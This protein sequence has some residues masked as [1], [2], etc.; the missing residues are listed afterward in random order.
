MRHI[1]S[2]LKQLIRKQEELDENIKRL[3]KEREEVTREIIDAALKELEDDKRNDSK[4]T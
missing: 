2:I 3:N 4:G 1:S